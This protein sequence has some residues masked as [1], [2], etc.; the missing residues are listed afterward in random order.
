MYFYDIKNI[1]GTTVVVPI[2]QNP[3]RLL[4]IFKYRKCIYASVQ[5]RRTTFEKYIYASIQH[6]NN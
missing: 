2:L 5:H 1:F 3:E 4:K 6:S